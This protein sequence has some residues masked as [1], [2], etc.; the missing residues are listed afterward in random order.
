MTFPIL[1]LSMAAGIVLWV[2]FEFAL[3]FVQWLDRHS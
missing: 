3:W 1:F 2:L